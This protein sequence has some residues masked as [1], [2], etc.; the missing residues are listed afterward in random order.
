MCCVLSIADCG[1][2]VLCIPCCDSSVMDLFGFR[3]GAYFAAYTDA[4]LLV[5]HFLMIHLSLCFHS[6]FHFLGWQS[7]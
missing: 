4:I 7:L 5:L 3:V 6:T 2:V 1:C